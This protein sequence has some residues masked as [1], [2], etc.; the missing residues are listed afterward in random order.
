M[1]KPHTSSN[2]LS[3]SGESCANLTSWMRRT[4]TPLIRP[5]EIL[6]VMAI[7]DGGRL[8]NRCGTEPIRRG[9]CAG[10]DAIF[11]SHRAPILRDA[12]LG[13][14]RGGVVQDLFALPPACTPYH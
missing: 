11:G 10:P 2:P 14:G 4:A 5:D 13:S 1:G 6:V 3:S 7:A 9:I 8:H 12:L